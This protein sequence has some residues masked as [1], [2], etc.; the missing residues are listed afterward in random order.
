M[1]VRGC[2]IVRFICLMCGIIVWFY[3]YF[4]FKSNIEYSISSQAMVSEH[5]PCL[6]QYD[7]GYLYS[8]GR[9]TIARPNP[10][11][12]TILKRLGILKY[13]GARGQHTREKRV[14][15]TNHGVN[16]HNLVTLP[17]S[18]NTVTQT[19]FRPPVTKPICKDSRKCNINLRK[20]KC[21][22]LNVCKG[23]IHIKVCCINP[24]SV[25]NKTL[26]M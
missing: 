1:N 25:K 20:I 11:T 5:I 26:L 12:L 6:R 3:G 23:G 2:T 8:I 17:Q 16:I 18:I 13:R 19:K 14:W 24:R 7:R 10:F 4:D 21:V 22:P 15:D 9:S